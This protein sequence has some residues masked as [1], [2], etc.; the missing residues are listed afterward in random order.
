MDKVKQKLLKNQKIDEEAYKARVK[1]L[2]MKKKRQRRD[3]DGEEL[4]PESED[5]EDGLPAGGV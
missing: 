5:D 1:A 3:R 4:D 2:R